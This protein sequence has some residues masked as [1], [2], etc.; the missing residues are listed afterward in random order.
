LLDKIEKELTNDPEFRD[1]IPLMKKIASLKHREVLI[2]TT[3][4]L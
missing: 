2:E 3:E 4:E 1:Q